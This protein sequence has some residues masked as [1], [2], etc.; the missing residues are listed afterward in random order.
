M[1]NVATGSTNVSLLIEAVGGD[2]HATPGTPQ[3]GLDYTDVA[4]IA[5]CIVGSAADEVSPAT[6]AG[7]GAAHSD[8]GMVEVEPDL[9]PGVYRVDLPDEIFAAAARQVALC[10]RFTEALKLR[11]ALLALA[12]VDPQ[13]LEDV[14]DR[15]LGPHQQNLATGVHTFYRQ[16]GTTVLMQRKAVEVDDDGDPAIRWDEP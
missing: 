1:I 5:W 15:F 4:S 7:P 13:P 10:V 11:D 16:D 2:D 3:T 6:L 14:H 9:M 8:G 12:V